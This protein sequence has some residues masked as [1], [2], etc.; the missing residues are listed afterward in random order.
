M[1]RSSMKCVHSRIFINELPWDA[2]I[3]NQLVDSKHS[4]QW[5]L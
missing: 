4:E 3:V 5:F 1:H 2:R